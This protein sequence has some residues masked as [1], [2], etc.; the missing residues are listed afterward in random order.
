MLPMFRL[1]ML[2]TVWEAKLELLLTKKEAAKVEHELEM[3]NV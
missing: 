1:L 3:L 2:H